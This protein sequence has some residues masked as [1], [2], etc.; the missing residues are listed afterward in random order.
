MNDKPTAAK[1]RRTP[2]Q[3]AGAVRTD[4]DLAVVR[5]AASIGCPPEEIAVL[6][7]FARSGF[8][9]RMKIDADV[10]QA[11]EDGRAEGRATLRR[12]QWQAAMNGVPAMLIWLGKQHLGQRDMSQIEHN[13]RGSVATASDADLL[14][15]ATGGSAIITSSETDQ[16]GT[17][18]MVH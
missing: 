4:V 2:A 3:D 6:L 11:V 17:E 15:I 10:R 7:G 8:Y 1:R 5:R 13:H 12:A 18:G 14:A 16:D 9:N